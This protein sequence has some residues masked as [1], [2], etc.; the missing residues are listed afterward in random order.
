MQKLLTTLATI[1]LIL[2]GLN[3]GLIGLFNLDVIA[4]LFGYFS[5]TTRVLYLL[6]G[7]SAAYLLIFHIYKC[8][9][10]KKA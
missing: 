3:W 9:R 8:C 6:V 1:L 2:G 10:N 5:L 4:A 7:A